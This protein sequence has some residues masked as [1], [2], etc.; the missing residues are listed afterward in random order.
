MIVSKCEHKI[1]YLQYNRSDKLQ[2]SCVVLYWLIKPGMQKELSLRFFCPFWM[3][4]GWLKITRASLRLNK[5]MSIS[6]WSTR[7]SDCLQSLLFSLKPICLY[8]K[9]FGSSLHG[10]LAFLRIMQYMSYTHIVRFLL[11]RRKSKDLPLCLYHFLRWHRKDNITHR[12][13]A[14]VHYKTLHHKIILKLYRSRNSASLFPSIRW[15]PFTHTNSLWFFFQAVSKF[16]CS[17]IL[18]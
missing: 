14:S 13:M 2:Q 6:Y 1:K 17:P 8:R 16:A 7:F 5:K 3:S 15:C 10:I 4:Q 11:L 12:L 9:A 18:S